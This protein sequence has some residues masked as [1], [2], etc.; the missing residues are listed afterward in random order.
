MNFHLE[1]FFNDKDNVHEVI[2]ELIEYL[3]RFEQDDKTLL[4][5]P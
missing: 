1:S 4:I 3:K 2:N 5:R